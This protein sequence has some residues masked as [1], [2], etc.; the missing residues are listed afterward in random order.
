MQSL[1]TMLKEEDAIS[2]PG[3]DLFDILEG[4]YSSLFVQHDSAAYKDD[5]Q[6]CM[7]LTRLSRIHYISGSG[8]TMCERSIG[9]VAQIS[10]WS[11]ASTVSQIRRIY[12]AN[13][14]EVVITYD[15]L[16]AQ[17]SSL[18]SYLFS[19]F[20]ALYSRFCT[21]VKTTPIRRITIRSC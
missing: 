1:N 21:N 19:G 6:P 4:T 11:V 18:Q 9:G 8:G 5:P 17:P 20:H 15:E 10:L 12:W 16:V 7:H 13:I 14:Q 3:Q 2:E